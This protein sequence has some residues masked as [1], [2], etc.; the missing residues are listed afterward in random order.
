MPSV[1]MGTGPA[2][3]TAP[4][5]RSAKPEPAGTNT[6]PG[7]VQNCPAPSVNEAARPLASSSARA[8]SA[9][10]VIRTG[11]TALSSP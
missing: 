7:L 2:C 1:S 3:P 11:F 6:T 9:A 4:A 5:T 10:A 8:S